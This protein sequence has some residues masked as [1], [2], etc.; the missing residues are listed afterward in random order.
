MKLVIIES[1]F[2]GNVDANIEYARQCV[3][4]SLLKG[5][6]PIASHLLYTQPDILNDNDYSER[7]LGITAGLAWLRV[8]DLSA[9]YTDLGISNGMQQGM[10]QAMSNGVT[11]EL[12][13]IYE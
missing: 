5:E 7:A 3:K 8:A 1:P 10:N 13:S 6:S 12:R 2:A 11:V 9:V 4:H